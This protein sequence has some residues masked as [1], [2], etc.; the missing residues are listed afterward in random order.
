MEKQKALVVPTRTTEIDGFPA[1]PDMQI[2]VHAIAS[3]TQATVLPEPV[4]WLDIMGALLDGEEYNIV[5]FCGHLTDEGL[6]LADEVISIDGL[7]MMFRGSPEHRKLIVVNTCNSEEAARRIASNTPC[8][9][10]GTIGE[11]EDRMAVSF[12][13]KFYSTLRNEHITDFRQAYNASV[14]DKKRF[15]FAEGTGQPTEDEEYIKRGDSATIAMIQSD[16]RE[17]KDII[18][19]GMRGNGLVYE[20]RQ[21]RL[22]YES[23]AETVEQHGDEIRILGEF[24]QFRAML[25][26]MYEKSQAL[27]PGGGFAPDAKTILAIAF[28]VFLAVLAASVFARGGF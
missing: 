4:G 13:V 19:G 8:A 18:T 27:T 23:L 3:S 25:M 26:R 28:T 12:A 9:V 17:M 24:K 6:I 11:I 10:I 2:E 22:L 15:I 20:Q 21:L 5:H 7:V 16:V 1:L 14:G